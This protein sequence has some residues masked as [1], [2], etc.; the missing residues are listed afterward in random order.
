MCKEAM[1][2]RGVRFL[3][4]QRGRWAEEWLLWTQKILHS[5]RLTPPHPT[6]PSPWW[7]WPGRWS[8][9]PPEEYNTFNTRCSTKKRCKGSHF[10]LKISSGEQRHPRIR[11][12]IKP[13]CCSFRAIRTFPTRWRTR[14]TLTF[15]RCRVL[16][17]I[18]PLLFTHQPF[19][20]D[21]L[22]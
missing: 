11:I 1:W 19:C 4:L 7:P 9:R 14:D 10:F 12:Y 2:H 21:K 18:C 8:L 16:L 17:H 20:K 13:Y 5:P 6:A 22:S 3:Y 15:V